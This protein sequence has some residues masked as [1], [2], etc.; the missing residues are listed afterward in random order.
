MSAS[1]LSRKLPR[2]LSRAI[3]VSLQRVLR[4][5]MPFLPP[6]RRPSTF[7]T[8]HSSFSMRLNTRRVATVAVDTSNCSRTASRLV[9][10]NFL[11]RLP[12]LSCSVL[13]SPAQAQRFVSYAV[14]PAR[15][16]YAL[17]FSLIHFIFR[18]KS[19]KTGEYEEKHL[20]VPPKPTIGK[21]TNLYTLVL[22]S[23]LLSHLHTTELTVSQPQ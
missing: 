5:I 12:G 14:Y 10:R 6:S 7:R 18:H 23:V 13:T 11:T 19:P 1:G 9:E 2:L 4:P 21:T 8:S 20:T 22:Q 17:S 16:T 15:V 3:M